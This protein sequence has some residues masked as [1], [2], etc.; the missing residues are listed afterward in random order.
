VIKPQGRLI[1]T[2]PT[3]QWLWSEHDVINHHRRRYTRATLAAAAR[4][5][6]WETTSS[7][8]FNGFLLPLAVAHRRLS[9]LR[10]SVD[11]P[12]SDLGRTPRRFNALLERPLDF[13][14]RMIARGRRI[15]AGLS[16]LAVLR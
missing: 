6:G 15:P 10:R 2:V 12:V 5:A 1:V 14:A 9:R 8:Y 4:G 3:Y 16:L 13:E 11:E 7:T